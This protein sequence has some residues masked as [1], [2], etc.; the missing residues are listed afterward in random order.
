MSKKHKNYNKYRGIMNLFINL[1]AIPA[2]GQQK[3]VLDKS[4][5]LKC[6]L[7]NSP[8]KGKANAELIKFLAKKLS[9]TK[10]QI[11]ITS[12]KTSRKKRIKIDAEMEY[13]DF[14]KKIGLK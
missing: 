11:I 7:K 8:E 10:K 13:S 1:K 5:I 4:G 6:Y 2:S 9:L 14:L 3:I 12:G